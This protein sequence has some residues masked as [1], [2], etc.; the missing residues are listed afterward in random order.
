MDFD[1]FARKMSDLLDE[2]RDSDYEDKWKIIRVVDDD[3][4]DE[5]ESKTGY[6]S[7]ALDFLYN[8]E[9]DREH[10]NLF[11]EIVRIEKGEYKFYRYQ[12]KDERGMYIRETI[13]SVCDMLDKG[14]PLRKIAEKLNLHF[15]TVCRIRIFFEEDK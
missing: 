1:T 5:E 2:M 9:Y 13:A 11:S 12:W 14:V 7:R 15:D 8:Q 6:T 3:D 4:E 10:E